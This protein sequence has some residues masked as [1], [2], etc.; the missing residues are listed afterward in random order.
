MIIL[1]W[2]LVLLIPIRTVGELINDKNGLGGVIG[3]LIYNI[4]LEIV[5]INYIYI[6][7]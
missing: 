7:L 5:F 2:I 6:L 4:A 1:L 3:I